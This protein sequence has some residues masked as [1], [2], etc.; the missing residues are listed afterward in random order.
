M[1][2][3]LEMGR[4]DWNLEGDLFPILNFDTEC[5]SRDNGNRPEK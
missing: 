5:V 3:D 1:A 2:Y 4:E